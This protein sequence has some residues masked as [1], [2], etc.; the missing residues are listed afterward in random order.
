MIWDFED[1][2]TAGTEIEIEILKDMDPEIIVK[3]YM[4]TSPENAEWLEE[5]LLDVDFEGVRDKLGRQ[6]IVEIEKAQEYIL[7]CLNKK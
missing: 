1:L 2:Y 4:G 5:N 7:D 3:A 6:P